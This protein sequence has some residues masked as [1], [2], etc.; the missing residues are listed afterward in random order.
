MAIQSR[1]HTE[2]GLAQRLVPPFA[3]VIGLLVVALGVMILAD[4]NAATNLLAFIYQTLGNTQAAVDLRNGIGDQF[5]AKLLLGVVALFVGVGGIWL[6]FTGAST[7]VGLPSP[8]MR[9][10]V[11]PWVFVAPASL[12]LTIFLVYP[13]VATLITSFSP[14]PTATRVPLQ[15]RSSTP[16]VPGDPPQQRPLADRRDRRQ[17]RPRPA[18]RGALRS[19]QA[20]VAG[21]DLHLH[22]ARDLARRRDGDLEVRVRSGSQRAS[23]SS[24][25]LNAIW[26][27]FGR[28]AGPRG[29]RRRSRSTLPADPHHD[30]APD[31]L[32]DG[33]PLGGD[34][35]R[36]GRGPRGRAARRRQRAP[37]L[38]PGHRAAH[39]R[40]D[41]HRHHHHRH[42]RR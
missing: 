40:L 31:R 15:G 10:R 22:A 8:K 41:R 28:R 33:R 21:Q 13:A 29:S 26:T 24:G 3:A 1:D 20:R 16:R 32:R 30:L 42:R 19:H 38:L 39:P 35:G 11:L 23:R 27:A 25:S 36:V 2:I 17:R 5:L 9:D 6:L 34:Q 37:D 4:R 14:R 7:L 12:L 18:D